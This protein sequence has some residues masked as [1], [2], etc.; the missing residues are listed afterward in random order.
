MNDLPLDITSTSQ[1]RTE[2]GFTLED[3]PWM[4]QKFS[5]SASSTKVIPHGERLEI[6]KESEYL[7]L[8]EVLKDAN[9]T[10]MGTEFIVAVMHVSLSLKSHLARPDV[11]ITCSLWS[12]DLS[13]LGKLKKKPRRSKISVATTWYSMNWRAEL[14]RRKRRK[15]RTTLA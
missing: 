6:C 7:D 14:S 1:R 3:G 11:L 9:A 15:K 2:K 13:T 12:T 5:T 4:C 10:S 8:V